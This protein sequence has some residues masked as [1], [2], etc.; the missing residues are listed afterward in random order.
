MEER[1]TKV[2]PWWN[3]SSC[4]VSWL[5]WVMVESPS[6]ELVKKHGDMAV[7]DMVRWWWYGGGGLMFGL[8]YLSDHF[9]W[10]WFFDS[11]ITSQH[12]TP[13]PEELI[14]DVSCKSVLQLPAQLA[15]HWELHLR[16]LCFLIQKAVMLCLHSL[17]REPFGLN[18]DVLTLDLI[19]VLS[20]SLSSTAR[21]RASVPK[22]P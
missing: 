5:C 1:P 21:N 9:Q 7:R 22:E 2:H 18:S 20:T 4:R 15:Q 14:P 13:V 3:Q 8:H 17:L 6:L 10:L 12:Y 11:V 19:S 16:H